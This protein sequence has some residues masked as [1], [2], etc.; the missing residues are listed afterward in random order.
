MASNQIENVKQLVRNWITA[1]VDVFESADAENNTNISQLL[2]SSAEAQRVLNCQ[3][4]QIE[5]VNQN[6]R[7][8]NGRCFLRGFSFVS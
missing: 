1:M 8:T 7:L 2:D 3:I 5:T 4:L 6:L